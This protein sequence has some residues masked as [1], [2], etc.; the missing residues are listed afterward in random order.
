MIQEI[1]KTG[2]LSAV[3]IFAITGCGSDST[4]TQETTITPYQRIASIPGTNIDIQKI[5]VK[6]SDY[7]VNTDESIALGFPTNWVIAGANPSANETY[8]GND[9]LIP[10]P[11]DT[12]TEVYTSRVIEFCNGAYATQATNTGQQR[13]SAL[14]CE[15]S[16]HSDGEN[17]YI[18]MLDADAIFTLFFPDTPDPDGKLKEMATAVKSEIRKMV[19]ASLQGEA[20]LIELTDALGPEFTT[21]ELSQIKDQDIYL[22]TQYKSSNDQTFTTTDAKKLA[23]TI[24]EKLG[25]DEVNADV[26][27]EGLSLGSAWRSARPDPIAIPGVF[28]TE[29]CSP[30]YAKMATRLGAEYITALPCEITAYLDRTDESNKTISISILSPHFMFENMFKGAV[31][32]AVRDTNLS[33]EDALKYQ[34]LADIVLADLSKITDEAVANSGLNLTKQ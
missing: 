9:D 10:I 29:A 28:V 31:D 6:I 27:V 21:T 8:E 3:A 7:V 32:N 4:T 26:H 20:N 5:A 19:M 33:Q 15:V 11:V 24:I 13:G 12:G 30:T 2:L 23:Q 22:V 17:I 25:T 14:P 34:T 1:L 16:V 18:D